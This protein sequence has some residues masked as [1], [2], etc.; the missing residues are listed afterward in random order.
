M[1]RDKHQ[2]YCNRLGATKED[3]TLAVVIGLEW[4]ASRVSED[5]ISRASASFTSA[6]LGLS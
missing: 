3:C 5:G 2:A 4:L 1:T 6:G